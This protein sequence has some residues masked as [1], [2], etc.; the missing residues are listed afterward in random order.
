[1]LAQTLIAASAAIAAAMGSGHMWLTF[2]SRAFSPRDSALEETMKT[3]P[4]IF[5][6]RLLMWKAWTGFNAS[7][8]VAPILFGLVYGYLA[9]V[10]PQF[11]FQSE[12]LMAVGAGTL[13]FYMFLAVRYW[14]YLPLLGLSV[15][16]VCYI[17]GII[18]A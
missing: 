12:F 3:V 13:A 8:S 17:A 16:F 2:F 18:A 5:N 6:K 10:R 4:T 7:H 9:L 15:A 11:L 14:F 1:M